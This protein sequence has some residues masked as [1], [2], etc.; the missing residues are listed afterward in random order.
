MLG[1]ITT[2]QTAATLISRNNSHSALR[3]VSQ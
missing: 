2:Q 1:F 3:L